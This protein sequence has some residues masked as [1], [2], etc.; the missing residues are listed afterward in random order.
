MFNLINKETNLIEFTGI[1]D[2]C[3]KLRASY[4]KELGGVLSKPEDY[5]IIE[6][7]K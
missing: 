3:L 2:E 1:Y 6:K 4:I 5:F 7:V